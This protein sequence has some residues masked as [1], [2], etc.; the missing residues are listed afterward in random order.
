MNR[1]TL[2]LIASTLAPSIAAAEYKYD[3][4]FIQPLP[5]WDYWYVL[6]IPLCLAIA[7]VYK[8]IRCSSMRRV[9][10]EALILFVFIMTVMLLA[11]GALAALVNVIR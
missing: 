3:R 9:P 5:V 7:V 4:P 8:S 2:Q 11:A 6:L 10:R 1:G